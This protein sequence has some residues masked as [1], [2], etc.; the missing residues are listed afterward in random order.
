MV[1]SATI[2]F[3]SENAL[4][5]SF[6]IYLEITGKEPPSRSWERPAEFS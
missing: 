3:I 6:S 1:A 4:K 2:F 5:Y